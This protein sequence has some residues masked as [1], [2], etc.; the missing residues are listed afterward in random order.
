[1]SS[2][3]YIRCHGE[4]R[5]EREARRRGRVGPGRVRAEA[6]GRAG[7]THLCALRAPCGRLRGGRGGR[8]GARAGDVSASLLPAPE[9]SGGPRPRRAVSSPPPGLASGIR[10]SKH[11]F[12]IKEAA[13]AAA[14]VR[15]ERVAL[16]PRAVNESSPADRAP[17]MHAGYTRARTRRVPP[18]RDSGPSAAMT[19]GGA[20]ESPCKGAAARF[21]PLAQFWGTL[22]CQ[23]PPH[24][25]KLVSRFGKDC[26]IPPG[27]I[28]ESVEER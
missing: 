17:M 15:P 21:L 7:G 19:P 27:C 6:G 8:G 28:N 16:S 9:H 10:T 12:N 23:V 5:G 24:F 11:L 3:Y 2:G 25:P 18:T 1:M 22:G 13:C 14:L 4:G 26:T 20:G